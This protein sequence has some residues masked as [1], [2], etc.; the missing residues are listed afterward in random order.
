MN[1]GDQEL[2]HDER[3]SALITIVSEL[4]APIQTRPLTA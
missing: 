1:F 4:L 2:A 3:R